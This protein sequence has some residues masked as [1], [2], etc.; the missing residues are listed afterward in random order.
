V[1]K[2]RNKRSRLWLASLRKCDS[3]PLFGKGDCE[4]NYPNSKG[5]ESM[6]KADKNGVK[7]EEGMIAWS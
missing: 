3:G 4:A 7:V 6:G 2:W 1:E 5:I